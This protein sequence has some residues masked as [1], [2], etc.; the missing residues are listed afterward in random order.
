MRKIT[1]A[2]T[3]VA[4]VTSCSRHAPIAGLVS[5]PPS[6]PSPPQQQLA[7]REDREGPGQDQPDAA[8]QFFVEQR[9]PDGRNIPTD[10]YLAAAQHR[11]RMRGYSIAS[12]RFTRDEATSPAQQQDLGGGWTNLGPQHIGGLTRAFAV[13]PKTPSIMYAGA[14]GGGIWKSIDSGATWKPL[15]DFL[16]SISV[17]WLTLDPMDPE[18]IYAGTG[19]NIGATFTIRGAGIY[20]SSDSGATWSVLHGTANDPNFYVVNRVLI[21]PNDSSH[22]YAAT[23]TGVW[24]SVNGGASFAQTLPRIAPNSGCEDLAM[25]SDQT[26]DYLYAACGR[27]NFTASAVFRNVDAAGSGTW[28]TVLAPT[29]MGATSLAIA[30]SNQSVVYAMMASVDPSNTDFNN[31][32]LAV[33]RSASNGDKDSWEI[34]ASNADSNRVNVSLLSNPRSTFADICSG[35]KPD[36]T[37]QGSHDNVLAVDPLNPDRVWAGGIDIFRSDDGGANWGIAMFWQAAQPISAH[38]DNHVLAF[39]PQYDGDKNQTLYNTSDGGIYVAKNANADVATGTRAGCLP[40]PSKIAWKSLNNGYTVTQFYDGTVFPG[41]N[42]YLAGAQDNGTHFGADGLNGEWVEVYG[43]DGGFVLV[44]P[45]DPN[46]I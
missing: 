34:R 36:H 42:Q 1:L 20:K 22:I 13:H 37:G 30:P 19:D 28:E 44:N 17:H 9:A 4:A 11:K 38:A 16:P 12:A 24:M 15:T 2:V 31:G 21:S 29:G 26:S 23:T 10:R 18:T 35:G 45:K 27:F 40:Y 33:Y 25:R 32:L 6:P 3:L 5:T 8:L 46:E 14:S 7:A 41:G 39:H 43:G